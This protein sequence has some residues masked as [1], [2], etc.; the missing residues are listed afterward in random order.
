M[1]AANLKN[2]KT[3]IFKISKH[4][5]S[6][7]FIYL[8]LRLLLALM[9]LFLTFCLDT[10]YSQNPKPEAKLTKLTAESEDLINFQVSV[11]KFNFKRGEDIILNYIITNKSKKNTV[12]LVNKP[13]SNVIVEDVAI[14]RIIQPVERPS[15]HTV[16]DY[17]LIKI[18]PQK[19]YKGKLTIS[20]EFYLSNKDYS[21]EISEIQVGFSYL[22]DKTLLGDCKGALVARPCLTE[23]Y[24]KSKSLTLG[25]LV[26]EIKTI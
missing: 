7:K 26:I 10:A 13:K 1:A 8:K 6:L 16:Y 9:L 12:Y 19:S 18:L 17:D 3:D 5:Q 25:N 15:D 11:S 4:F 14:L 22:F 24:N 23:L 21:F 2:N 20:A